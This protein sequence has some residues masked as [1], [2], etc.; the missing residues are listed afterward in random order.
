MTTDL[1]PL[2]VS[3]ALVTPMAG[4][5]HKSPIFRDLLLPHLHNLLR[6]KEHSLNE[7]LLESE[8]VDCSDIDHS[9]LKFSTS[10][11]NYILFSISYVLNTMLGS[12][13]TKFM[14]S[15]VNQETI[16]K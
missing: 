5:R 3:P 16:L 14:P 12:K 4:F 7:I 1:L 9:P 2:S 10:F 11:N 8:T 13:I 6:A 15:K